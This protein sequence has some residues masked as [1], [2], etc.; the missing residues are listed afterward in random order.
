MIRNVVGGRRWIGDAVEEPRYVRQP[1][2]ADRAQLQPFYERLHAAIRQHDN[3]TLI[4]YAGMELGNFM[5][6]PVGFEHGPGGHGWDEKQ[7]LVF[8]NC[9][10][11][12]HFSIPRF[13]S[14][15][16]DGFVRCLCF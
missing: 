8:H 2:L 1:G 9:A 15:S 5:A 6:A 16:A 4:L 7:A 3:D 14:S 11:L 10:R 12:L 13:C